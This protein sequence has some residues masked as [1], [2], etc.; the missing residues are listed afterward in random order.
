MF[1]ILNSCVNQMGRLTVELNACSGLLSNDKIRCWRLGV[2]FRAHSCYLLLETCVG[3]KPKL[4][5]KRDPLPDPNNSTRL[6]PTH[7]LFFPF[8]GPGIALFPRSTPSRTQ[9]CMHSFQMHTKTH[10]KAV[11]EENIIPT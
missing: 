2:H 9:P 7:L 1:T 3:I 10:K 5:C 11:Y 4:E 6:N 8:E